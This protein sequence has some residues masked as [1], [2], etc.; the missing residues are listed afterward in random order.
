MN[1]HNDKRK[2]IDWLKEKFNSSYALFIPVFESQVLLKSGNHHKAIYLSKDELIKE[3]DEE[4]FIFLGEINGNYYFAYEIDEEK[5]Q[6]LVSEEIDYKEFIY[7]TP[8]L[9]ELDCSLLSF[10][11]SLLLWHNQTKY[12][13][14]CGNTTK[15]IDGG[16]ARICTNKEC[17]K[18]S[19]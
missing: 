18:G 9:N 16:F 19:D 6:S 17:K 4:H 14:V 10:G 15:S 13:G 2:N 3:F 8:L 5:K 1:R 11:R 7:I 12:C